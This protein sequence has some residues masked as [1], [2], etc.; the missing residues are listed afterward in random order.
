MSYWKGNSVNLVNE[1]VGERKALQGQV[2]R[3]G[4]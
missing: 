3:K 2:E 4:R 1:W